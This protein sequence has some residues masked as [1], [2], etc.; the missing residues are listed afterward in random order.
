MTMQTSRHCPMQGGTLCG[1]PDCT[2]S[3]CVCQRLRRRVDR[4]LF[5]LSRESAVVREAVMLAL[6]EGLGATASAVLAG[7]S[8]QDTAD[9]LVA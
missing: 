7:A 1:L 9:E 2:A 5:P 8:G 3:D 6:A 4:Y